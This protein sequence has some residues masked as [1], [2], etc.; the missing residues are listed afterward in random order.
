MTIGQVFEDRA[1]GK[2]AARFTGQR[3]PLLGVGE[4]E[5]VPWKVVVLV[6][7]GI[8]AR[9]G[10]AV[11]GKSLPRPGDMRH[12]PVEHAF[13]GLVG[14]EPLVDEVAQEP[15]RLR[16]A[17]ADRVLDARD[18]GLGI[19]AGIA[20]QERD[21]VARRDERE[22][23]GNSLRRRIDELVDGAGILALGAGDL[24]RAL[25]DVAERQPVGRF[26]GRLGGRA[27][28]QRRQGRIHVGRGIAQGARAD[29]LGVVEDEFLPRRSG[30]ALEHRQVNRKEFFV[31]RR[32]PAAPDQGVAFLHHEA[33]A[34]ILHGEDVASARQVEKGEAQVPAP[35]RDLVEQRAGSFSGRAQDDHFR[36]ELDLSV[37]VQGGLVDID[38]PGSAVRSG[39]DGEMRNASIRS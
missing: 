2:D 9:L 31:E 13:P 35:V 26:A 23:R 27:H 7:A 38:D 19:V 36:A 10:E 37:I 21:E 1:G 32:L 25:V 3:I 18:G 22:A 28:G 17:H 34:G 6:L 14:I 39:I 30:H 5:L 16:D 11:V 24:D 4:G 15:A 20:A 8:P 12:G 29:G 33:V